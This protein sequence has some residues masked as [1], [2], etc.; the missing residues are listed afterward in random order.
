MK[1]NNRNRTSQQITRNGERRVRS[2][3]SADTRKRSYEEIPAPSLG[4]KK[5]GPTIQERAQQHRQAAQ[6]GNKNNANENKKRVKKQPEVQKQATSPSLLSKILNH[7][8]Q[9]GPPDFLIVELVTILLVIGLIMVF[10]ASSYRSL[11][12]S[13]NAFSYFI[14]QLVMATAGVVAMIVIMF[15]SPKIFAKVAPIALLFVTGLIVYTLFNG[16]ETLGATRWVTIAGM[17]F[18]PSELAKPLMI[19]CA[20]DLVKDDWRDMYRSRENLC[21]LGLLLVNLV[22]I[23]S[24][25]LGSALAIFGG[26]FAL[27]IVAGISKRVIL[28][29]IA[30]GLLGVV[31]ACIQ[32]PYRVHRILGFL[33]QTEADAA[34]GSAYQLVQSLYAFGSGGLFGVGLGNSGQK[35]LYLPGMHT[36]F[37]YSVIGEEL[38][39]VGALLVLGLFIAL[40][41]R[42]FW[43]ATRIEDAYKSYLAFGATAIILVQAL[44]NMGVAVGVLPVTG[45]TLP[46]ISY[47]G[48]SVFVSLTL[49]GILLNMSRY[50]DKKSSQEKRRKRQHTTLNKQES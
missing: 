32:E 10:S 8:K 36:D 30:A 3:Q 34:S 38:G 1:E 17:R 24:E 7:D 12:E 22:L 13:S 41:W 49:V 45:I 4:H 26:C 11:L 37:I 31:A 16:E 35:L 46:F 39:I 15:L 29:T 2:G 25:D 14:R 6:P 42:G 23:A 47:G 44:I 27:F 19:I 43:I 5:T 20:A 18:T 50:A 33:N 9:A 21:M 40:G 28:G 48:T